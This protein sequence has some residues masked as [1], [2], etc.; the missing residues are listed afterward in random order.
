MRISQLSERSGVPP[1]TLRFYETAGLLTPERT[2]SGYRTYGED[3]LD[4]LSLIA[5]VKNLGLPL[6]EIAELLTVWTSGACTDVKAD[7]RPR[8]AAH[9]SEAEHRIADLTA[10][11]AALR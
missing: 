3:A 8:V 7:L 5:A 9:L 10:L 11:T 2:P 1:T 6:A 4:R